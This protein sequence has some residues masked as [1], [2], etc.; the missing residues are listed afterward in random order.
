MVLNFVKLSFLAQLASWAIHNIG[1]WMLIESAANMLH[2]ILTQSR[3]LSTPPETTSFHTA[4][5][6]LM[7]QAAIDIRVYRLRSL[8]AL[9]ISLLCAA[10][11]VSLSSH[12]YSISSILLE[13]CLKRA[14]EQLSEATWKNLLLEVEGNV[15][16]CITL[17]GDANYLGYMSRVCRI[18]KWMCSP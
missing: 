1:L 4:I 6:Q 7:L 12:S 10:P 14:S 3:D 16:Q 2:L 15:P 13:T 8:S 17:A 11:A 5:A 9:G 18:G